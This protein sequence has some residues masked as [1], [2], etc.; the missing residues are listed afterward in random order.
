METIS[1]GLICTLLGAA[2]SFLTFQR[3]SKKDIQSEVKE[4]V[5]L[6]TKLDYISKGVDDIKFNDRIRDEQLK[7]INDR[8]IIAEE[9]IKILFSRFERLDEFYH[10]RNE[11]EG[12]NNHESIHKQN[13]KL[14]RG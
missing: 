5:E 10:I 6:K 11:L 7:K 4:Q 3:N 1:I 14:N 8:L 9:E 12:V 2:I 13:N